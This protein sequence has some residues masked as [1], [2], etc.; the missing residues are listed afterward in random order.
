MPGWRRTRWP[1]RR[2][3]WA[4]TIAAAA[5]SGFAPGTPSPCRRSPR[6]CSTPIARTIPPPPATSRPRRCASWATV[7]T[8]CPTGSGAPGPSKATRTRSP[9]LSPFTAVLPARLPRWRYDE[10]TT[11]IEL[12]GLRRAYEAL[13]PRVES[14]V[15]AA[16]AAPAGAAGELRRVRAE[17]VSAA[18]YAEA[19]RSRN[20]GP[21]DRGEARWR[22]LDALEHAYLLGQ[23]LALP[24][25]VEVARVRDKREDELPLETERSWL[26]I[27]PGCPVL[28]SE[29]VRRRCPA[30]PRRRRDRRLRGARRR[31]RHRERLRARARAGGGDD[32]RGGDQAVGAQG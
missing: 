1:R 23:L 14:G 21:I 13:E 17:M 31:S 2:R 3:R 29:G 9:A 19:I 20:A 27:E 12:H 26:Q 16:A 25:L 5:C 10:P 8:R 11:E 32:R 4:A 7:S 28:D 22:L 18:D 24:T 30:R 6:R 15:Q